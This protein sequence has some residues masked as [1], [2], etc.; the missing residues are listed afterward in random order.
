[1]QLHDIPFSLQSRLRIMIVAALIKGTKDF[2]E[3]KAATAAT[4]GN[5]GKQLEVL[6]AEKFITS[7]RERNGHRPRTSQ[8]LT[9]Y[10]RSAFEEYVALLEGIL[11]EALAE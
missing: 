3:L 11:K 10:G 5:L 2:R 6:E 7:S 8:T 9:V 4:D 1:M